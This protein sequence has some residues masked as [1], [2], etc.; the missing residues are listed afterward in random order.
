MGRVLVCREDVLRGL[1]SVGQVH[2]G[3]K[4]GGMG[5]EEKWGW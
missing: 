5:Q 1:V 2:G 3:W 4:G